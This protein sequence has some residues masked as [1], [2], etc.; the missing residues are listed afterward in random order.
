M[1]QQVPQACVENETGQFFEV[2]AY[3]KMINEASGLPYNCKTDGNCPKIGLQVRSSDG[4]LSYQ[5]ISNSYPNHVDD[6]TQFTLY[7]GTFELTEQLANAASL[8]YWFQGVQPGNSYILD[9]VKFTRINSPTVS[10]TQS[11][12]TTSPTESPSDPVSCDNWVLNPGA[13]T[14]DTRSWTKMHNSGTLE[15]VDGGA[16]GTSKAFK[17]TDIVHWN[18]GAM[19]EIRSECLAESGSDQWLEIQAYLKIA[20]QATGEAYDCMTLGGCPRLTFQVKKADGAYTYISAGSANHQF[21]NVGGFNLYT[22]TFKMN[23]DMINAQRIW[24]WFEGVKP[25]NMYWLDE[26]KIAMISSP[27]VS[28]TQSPTTTSPTEPPSDPVSCD[29]WVLNPGAETGDTRSWTKMHNSGTLEVVDG[30]ADGTSKAFKMTDIVH[31][32]KGAM[33]EIRSECLAESGSDQWLE[34]QAYLKIAD[35]ATGE[36]YDCMTLGGCPRLTFQVKKADGAYT[37]ISAGSANHQFTN[38]GGFNLYTRTFKMNE[39]MINAQRIWFWFEGVKPGNMYWLDEAKIAMISSPT[40]SPTRSPIEFAGNAIKGDGTAT[41][42]NIGSSPPTS[43][44]NKYNG[45]LL[46][47]GQETDGNKYFHH[48]D[49]T[50]S[51]WGLKSYVDTNNLVVGDYRFSI[52]SRFM[53]NNDDTQWDYLLGQLSWKRA[54]EDGGTWGHTHFVWVRMSQWCLFQQYP[55]LLLY[56]IIV[57]V[58][59]RL[60]CPK[61]TGS[62]GWMNCQKIV[63]I[64]D[65]KARAQKME[66]KMTWRASW[67]LF[68]A[69]YDNVMFEEYNPVVTD[70]LVIGDGSADDGIAGFGIY[71]QGSLVIRQD[72]DGN[73]YFHNEHRTAAW[74]GM[75]ANID[76]SRFVESKTYRISWK[77][78]TYSLGAD[79]MRTQ[80]SWKRSDNSWGHKNLY[81]SCLSL[82]CP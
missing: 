79:N 42:Y 78:R 38:V 37:Y 65:E 81:V 30:G 8:D 46:T 80:L 35:Q 34:I 55:L 44:Y 70:N 61:T 53:N 66:I 77:Y 2:Q 50:S 4:S 74:N 45:G 54:A 20:D 24:F 49:R 22:R 59:F 68:D 58:S 3:F 12:T 43:E 69:D 14:G 25:G 62:R 31:W 23:E 28:P 27:T 56:L 15:V 57:I 40:T 10:P 63:S 11:P 64:D 32:N 19:Q 39:D 51:W 17:M 75:R 72:V 76:T 9:E 5:V 60:Q 21:T 82:L 16:D 18:K 48:T 67:N 33:Q 47:I 73:N 36:A 7:R 13:E 41:V 29:N 52:D 71:N 1:L 26:A 6:P